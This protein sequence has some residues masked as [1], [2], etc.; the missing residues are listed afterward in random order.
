MV[1]SASAS[2]PLTRIQGLPIFKLTG[3]ISLLSKGL[4]GVFSS[5]TDQRHQFFGAPPFLQSSSHNRMQPMGRC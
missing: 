2:V 3:L 1:A 4:L 5:T